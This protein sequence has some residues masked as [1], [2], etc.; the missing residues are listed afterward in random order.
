[1]KASAVAL[2]SK[3]KAAL[4]A[5]NLTAVDRDPLVVAAVS[6]LV[7]IRDQVAWG[8]LP[9]SCIPELW[10]TYGAQIAAAVSGV[11]DRLPLYRSALARQS[12]P[13]FRDLPG[14]VGQAFAL[15]FQDKWPEEGGE[16]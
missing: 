11:Y 2:L 6:A 13:T 3:G 14:L 8:V 10:A 7:H 15:G 1:M 5:A 12:T 9:E 16:E 4:L